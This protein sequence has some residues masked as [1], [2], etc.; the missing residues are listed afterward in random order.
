[1]SGLNFLNLTALGLLGLSIPVVLLYL[2]KMKRQD[3]VVPS[4]LLWQSVIND[5]Q[6]RHP[7][8]KLR[9]NLL[10]ILQLLALLMLVLA[11]MRPAIMA[12][13]ESGRSI[14]LII[15][16][17]A[18]MKTR[19]ADGQTRFDPAQDFAE[20]LIDSLIT[21]KKTD[22][23]MIISAGGQPR[24]VKRFTSDKNDLSRALK[25]IEPADTGGNLAE[26]FNLSASVL[27]NKTTPVIYLL[28]DTVANPSDFNHLGNFKNNLKFIKFGNSRN[29]I[30][31]V[32]FD[33]R[34]GS[35]NAVPSGSLLEAKGAS[36]SGELPYEIFARIINTNGQEQSGTVNLYYENN[37]IA[38]K[39]LNLPADTNVSVTFNK[40]LPPGVLMLKIEPEDDFPVDNTVWTVLRP[41]GEIKVAVVSHRENIFLKQVYESIPLTAVV[42]LKPEEFS[43]PVDYDLVIYDGLIPAGQL[44]DSGN[45]VY[46]NPPPGVIKDIE[47][48][49]PIKFPVILD[50]QKS[51]SLL[52]FVDF[53]DVHIAEALQVSGNFRGEPILKSAS[54]S[55]LMIFNRRPDGYFKLFVGFDIFQS[56]WPLRAS[57]PIFFHNLINLTRESYSIQYPPM[58][59]AGEIIPLA[60]IA[61]ESIVTI[62]LPDGRSVNLP[63]ENT[64]KTQGKRIRI[65]AETLQA[66]L[67]DVSIKPIPI[68]S[69]PGN[70]ELKFK[71]AANLLN[72]KESR[73]NPALLLEN[74]NEIEVTQSR[75]LKILHKEIWFWAVWV[76]LILFLLEWYVFH[77]RVDN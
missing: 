44:Q 8:Q 67:Y 46:L 54:G 5:L 1:M 37:L 10:L 63:S 60:G 65:F 62:T 24:V 26:V 35:L 40:N 56:D 55:P 36:A 71:F 70:E 16:T 34:P 76:V 41:A 11:L 20:R 9:R 23:M 29:N 69:G 50:W 68:T 25:E 31:F 51:H 75:E 33:V 48:T 47:I 57:F 19:E 32:R 12:S 30:G 38:A 7:F 13:V 59:P 49:G 43:S 39:E 3:R 77:R 15:D 73:I 42:L 52:R 72:E 14:V 4:I 61:D 45:A 22:E 18:S 64:S 27:K 6:A 53:Q 28:S 74:Q 21:G 2:L 17:T 66:G 58:V